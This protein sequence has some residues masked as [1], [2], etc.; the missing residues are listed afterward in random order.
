MQSF[1]CLPRG[2]ARQRAA[3]GIFRIAV[4]Q[5]DGNA[6]RPAQKADLDAGSRRMRLLGE[7]D[8]LLPEIGRDCIDARDRKAEMVETLIRRDW[9]RIDAVTGIDLCKKDH[10]AAK[11]DVHAWL[12]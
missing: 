7:L 11:P 5:L 9:R 12:A 3:S 2:V 10:G 8:A 6:L 1:S 4:E